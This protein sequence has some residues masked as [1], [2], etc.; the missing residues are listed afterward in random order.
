LFF[1]QNQT[2]LRI[3]KDNDDILKELQIPV[4]Y[5]IISNNPKISIE[6]LQANFSPKLI[7]LD[8]SNSNYFAQKLIPEAEKIGIPLYTVNNSGACIIKL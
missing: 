2:F 4:D 3:N 5:L 7:I 6:E 1:F 8:S